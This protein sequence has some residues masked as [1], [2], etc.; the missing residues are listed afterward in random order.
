MFVLLSNILILCQINTKIWVDCLGH[1]KCVKF[2]INFST[3]Y[4]DITRTRTLDM[5]SL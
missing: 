1:V 5:I 3:V 4:Y 2:N